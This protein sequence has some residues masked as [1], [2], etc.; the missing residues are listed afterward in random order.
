MEIEPNTLTAQQVHQ[1]IGHGLISL[2]R[3][4]QSLLSRYE[5]R[6]A[7]V[8]AWA[9]INPEKVL[10]EARELDSIPKEERGS[11]HGF[12]IAVKDVMSTRGATPS[13]ICGFFV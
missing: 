11:L 1:L 7:N 6:D 13:W 4:V 5:A 9:S 2:E 10:E 8:N 12:V 3:Y